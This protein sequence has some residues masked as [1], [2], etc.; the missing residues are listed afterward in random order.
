MLAIANFASDQR[1]RERLLRAINDVLYMCTEATLI[2]NAH[3]RAG[4]IMN[5]GAPARL[6]LGASVKSALTRAIRLGISFAGAA[7]THGTS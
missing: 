3:Q 5:K 4:T 1:Q 7:L 6:P 2:D